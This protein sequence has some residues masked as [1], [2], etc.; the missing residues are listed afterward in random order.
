MQDERGV[1]YHPFP[2]NPRVRMYVREAEGTL[3]FRLW[4]E[5]DLALW[6]DHGWIAWEAVQQAMALRT[7]S[8]FDPKRA[9]DPHVA[10]AVLKEARGA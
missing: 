10:R 9:Y 3:F 1:F 4:S 7:P 2:Q 8:N 6:D 5:D